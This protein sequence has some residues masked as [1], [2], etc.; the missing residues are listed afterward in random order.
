MEN[1]SLPFFHTYQ[2]KNLKKV[3]FHPSENQKVTVFGGVLSRYIL[4]LFGGFLYPLVGTCNNKDF[5]IFKSLLLKVPKR[6]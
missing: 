3:I 1:K 4:I 6:G 2:E 5:K